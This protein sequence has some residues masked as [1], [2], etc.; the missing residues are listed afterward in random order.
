MN[1]ENPPTI[2]RKRDETFYGRRKGRPLRS[3]SQDL[4][5]DVLPKITFDSKHAKDIQAS[6][7]KCS[8]QVWLEIGFGGGE[9]LC[10][11]AKANP[12][13]NMIGAEA[14]INGVVMLM[15]EMNRVQERDSVDTS[16]NVR[17]WPQDVR[18][19]LD[20][21]PD[22]SIDRI[23]LLFPD[24]WPKSRHHKRRFINPKNL[25]RLARIIKPGGEFRFA[26]DHAEYVEWGVE[27]M[28]V[29]KGFSPNFSWDDLP[30]QRPADWV[31]TRYEQKALDQ[32]IVCTYLS[33]TR[34]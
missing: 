19:L 33:F 21:L 12:D 8:S 17:V 24:P 18:P 13:V 32:G 25:E 2:P 26:S 4:I 34:R 3:N 5:N 16:S 10:G 11:Q 7:P 20:S 6:F 29:N 28:K 15:R 22:N 27:R 30:Q 1:T 14:F 31:P 23:F 9:H